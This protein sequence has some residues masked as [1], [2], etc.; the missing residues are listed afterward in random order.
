MRTGRGA[1]GAA[2]SHSEWVRERNQART[3]WVIA[4][5]AFWVTLAV[6]GV[7]YLLKS[8]L[9]LVLLS[10]TLGAMVLGVWLKTRYQLILRREPPNSEHGEDHQPRV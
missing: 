8:E 1:Q 9:D 6:L 5:L 4:V 7:V 10:V 3:L 2:R